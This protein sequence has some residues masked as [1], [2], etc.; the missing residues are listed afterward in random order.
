MCECEVC[1]CFVCTVSVFA[2]YGRAGSLQAGASFLVS[3][4]LF[5]VV[6]FCKNMLVCSEMLPARACA[7]FCSCRALW[8]GLAGLAGHAIGWVGSY[9]G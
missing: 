8:A 4:I 1:V 6:P 2:S 7:V 9:W 5:F 3:V